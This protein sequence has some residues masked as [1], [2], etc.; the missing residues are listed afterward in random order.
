M[1]PGTIVGPRSARV[2][3]MGLVLIVH[4]ASPINEDTTKTQPCRGWAG[5]LEPP[6]VPRPRRVHM[7]RM[8]GSHAEIRKAARSHA[9]ETKIRICIDDFFL[10]FA[11]LRATLRTLREI[12]WYVTRV[13][14]PPPRVASRAGGGNAGR[15]G[16]RQRSHHPFPGPP[17]ARAD[18]FARNRPRRAG[19]APAV[20]PDRAAGTPSDPGRSG[21]GGPGGSSHRSRSRR[22]DRTG[23]GTGADRSPSGR[24]R[25]RNRSPC[26][27]PVVVV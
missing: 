9:E 3:E 26:P 2:D 23:A 1:F 21:R 22:R 19:R 8:E 10:L 16:R 27:L 7:L 12:R 18:R 13:A 11:W 5:R 4:L 25:G 20:P 14:A 24:R 15:N 17:A 6:P